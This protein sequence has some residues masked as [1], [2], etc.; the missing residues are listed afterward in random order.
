[1]DASE[2][3][4]ALQGVGERA[5]EASGSGSCGGRSGTRD[6]LGAIKALEA[7]QAEF[8]WA[9]VLA[10]TNEA[11]EQYAREAEELGRELA[12]VHREQAQ[13]QEAACV[14][15]REKAAVR[16]DGAQ[17]WAAQKARHMEHKQQQLA[18]GAQ[19]IAAALDDLR[20]VV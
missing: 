4:R 1:M 17:S 11:F 14:L 2:V 18:R 8:S 13:W 9:T 7:G 16:L 5:G 3:A 6:G 20:A 19:A 15:D 10:L 12:A